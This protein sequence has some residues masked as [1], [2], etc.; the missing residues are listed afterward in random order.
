MNSWFTVKVKY[1]KQFQNGTLKR[2][3]EPYLLGALSFTDAEARI[4]E[5]LGTRIRGEFHILGI[6][7]TEIQ[8]IFAYDDTG[9][10]YK[11][12]ISYMVEN[13]ENEKQKKISQQF[14]VEADSIK[15]AYER[16]KESLSS[17]GVDFEIPSILLSPI[18]D[19]FP[20]DETRSKIIEEESNEIEA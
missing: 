9:I 18:I 13:D 1:T 7:R 15:E 2:V 12:K 4:Y 19:I 5:E 6:T 10:W 8:D 16:L 17:M 20:N 3:S 11:C 14:L